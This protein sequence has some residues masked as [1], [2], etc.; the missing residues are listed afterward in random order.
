M[1]LR[2]ET[3]TTL[4][5]LTVI[6]LAGCSGCAQKQIEPTAEDEHTFQAY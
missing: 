3:L 4:L 1:K 6:L 5:M 2:I